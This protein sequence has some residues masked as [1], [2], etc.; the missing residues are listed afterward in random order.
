[1]TRRLIVLAVL[2]AALVAADRALQSAQ[3]ARRAESVRIAAFAPALADAEA[4]AA[5]RVETGA[6]ES[7][8]YGRKQGQWRCLTWRGAL[9]DGDALM[10]LVSAITDAVGVPL[11]ERPADPTDFG[12]DTPGSF[13]VTLHGP[14]A[15]RLDPA[16]DRLLAVD[17]GATLANGAGCFARRH[18]ETAVWSID[19]V[20]ASGLQREPGARIPPLVERRLVPASWP[21][22]PVRIQTAR[23]EHAGREPFE[24]RLEERE[25][26]DEEYLA[27]RPPF[28]W[29]LV[30]RDIPEECAELLAL[31]F[32]Q[33][34]LEARWTGLADPVLAD[35]LGL[36][37]PRAKLTL[38]SGEAEPFEL[39]LGAKLPG[40]VSAVWLPATQQLC[41]IPPNEEAL[42]FPTEDAFAVSATLNPW[43]R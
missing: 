19:T 13:T 22:L 23:V 14:K 10:A 33:H 11:S 38:L 42:L 32:A 6:G 39:I 41:E 8:L 43:E 7:W 35:H 31:Y 16:Q 29:V 34:V 40:G 18:G 30:R 12:L 4:L 20:P 17:L 15:A 27:G 9:A 1:M 25:I 5:V 26:S 3:S 2:V 28:E 24:L 36:D 21:G 37:R